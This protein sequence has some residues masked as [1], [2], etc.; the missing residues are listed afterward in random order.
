MK[1]LIIVLAVLSLSAVIAAN[2]A[3]AGLRVGGGLHYLRTVGDLKDEEGFDENSFSFLGSVK[4]G[5]GLLTVEGD[6]EY[7]HDY[8]G[9]GLYMIQPQ[10]YA[11]VGGLIYGGAGIGVGN[12][13]EFGWQEP[14]YALR[15]GVDL[16]VGPVDLDIFGS[17][18][19]Q[20]TDDLKTLDS[21]DL[22]AITLGAIVFVGF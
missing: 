11:L 2:S 17:Y 18:R 14:F 16:N 19:F 21:D 9:S 6:L 13:E 20:K 7:I 22:D 8:V 10:A 4:Y 3:N 1:R 5:F 15:A 12:L